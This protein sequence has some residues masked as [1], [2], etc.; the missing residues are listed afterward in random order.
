MRIMSF[1]DPT[2][3]GGCTCPRCGAEFACGAIGAGPCACTQ[4]TLD[5][6]MLAQLRARYVGCLCPGCLWA[7]A[8]GAD[9]EGDEAIRPAAPLQP[10]A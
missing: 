5:A 2:A 8:G 9:L 6:L 4:V 1:G 3:R 10:R 7:L